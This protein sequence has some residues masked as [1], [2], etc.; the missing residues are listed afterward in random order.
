MDPTTIKAKIVCRSGNIELPKARVN[1][2]VN[3]DGTKELSSNAPPGTHSRD[4]GKTGNPLIEAFDLN[5]DINGMVETMEIKVEYQ[6]MP[7]MCNA[8]DVFGHNES[9]C[10]KMMSKARIN[11]EEQAVVQNLCTD[12]PVLCINVEEQ[13]AVQN[14][15]TD[16]PVLCINK[17][18]AVASVVLDTEIVE[19]NKKRVADNLLVPGTE[20]ERYPQVNT[21]VTE[22]IVKQ[23]A[24]PQQDTRRIT[25]RNKFADLSPSWEAK[26]SWT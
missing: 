9:L 21:Q 16:Q 15:C 4:K 3:P 7:K 12:Q 18:K 17:G 20:I 11:V 5:V 6:W 2:K 1:A 22:I 14:L 26:S 19:T 23:V 10:P 24:S 13:A 8:C 25:S